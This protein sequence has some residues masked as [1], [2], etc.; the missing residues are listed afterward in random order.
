MSLGLIVKTG[1]IL[2]A[3]LLMGDPIEGITHC[4]IGEGDATFTDPL[5]P[6][7]PEIE[8]TALKNERARKKYYKRTFLKEDPEGALIVNG[9]HYIETTEET[10]GQATEYYKARHTLPP[11][12]IVLDGRYPVGVAALYHRK[13]RAAPR[14]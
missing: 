13:C 14:S 3:R 6:P 1:R 7:A 8:Q 5:N 2:T 10:G 4:A 12:N 11:Y 9:I